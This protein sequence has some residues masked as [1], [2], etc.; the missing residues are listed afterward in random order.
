LFDE[1]L[2]IELRGR[3]LPPGTVNR[4]K[5]SLLTQQGAKEAK[6]L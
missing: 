4:I 1:I 6:R 3:F 2:A 5:S